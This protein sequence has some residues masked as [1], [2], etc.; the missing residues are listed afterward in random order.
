LELEILKRLWRE[1]PMTVREVRESLENDFRKLAHTSVITM[2]NIMVDKGY[3][4][5]TKGRGGYVYKAR[6]RRESTLR[7]MMGD[8]VDRAYEGSAAAA[9]MQLLDGGSVSAQE[10]EQLRKLLDRKAEEDGT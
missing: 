1:G 2:M 10:L 3:A 5:K 8:L 9:A 4:S 7:R 6:I